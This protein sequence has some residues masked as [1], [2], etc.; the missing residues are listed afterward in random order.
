[1]R[2]LRGPIAMLLFVPGFILV[3]AGICW[4]IFSLA[5]SALARP[6]PPLETALL[7]AVPGVI[8]GVVGVGLLYASRAVDG[9][10]GPVRR[11][12]RQRKRARV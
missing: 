11:Y 8:V 6:Q 1:M 3:A 12:V 7:G 2:R 5:G 4:V 10:H 9:A